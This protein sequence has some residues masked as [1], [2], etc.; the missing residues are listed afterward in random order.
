MIPFSLFYPR[1]FLYFTLI[2]SLLF[3]IFMLHL[4]LNRSVQLQNSLSIPCAKKKKNP[5]KNKTKNKNSVIVC[6]QSFILFFGCFISRF[7]SL[8]LPLSPLFPPYFFFHLC[9]KSS[10]S[11]QLACMSKDYIKLSSH[12]G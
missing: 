6:V 11:S 1:I 7:F 8:L 9:K 10:H 5:Q 3:R 4:S 2:I 12:H